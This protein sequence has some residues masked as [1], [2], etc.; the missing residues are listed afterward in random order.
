[1]EIATTCHRY[2]HL[3]GC[4]S[5]SVQTTMLLRPQQSTRV[6][7][8]SRVK[9]QS[10]TLRKEHPDQHWV[11][12]YKRYHLEWLIETK[13]AQ[14][15]SVLF[16]GQDDKARIPVGT[17]IA[18]STNVRS[19]NGAIVPIGTQPT[20]ADH[21]WGYASI[22][23]SVTL[24][25]NIPA[26]MEGSFYGGGNDGDGKIEVVLRDAVFDGSDVFDHAAQLLETIRKE[27]SL[28]Y[29]VVLETDGGPD[30]NL[31]FMRTWLALIALFIKGDLDKLLALR[32]A[33]NG[34]WLNKTERCMSL[35]NFGI[36]NVSLVRAMM[37]LWAERQIE[38]ASS[39]K[40]IRNVAERLRD[41]TNATRVRANNASNRR[42][43]YSSFATTGNARLESQLVCQ[44]RKEGLTCGFFVLTY[45]GRLK[46]SS[47]ACVVIA[48]NIALT[49]LTRPL[50]A[51]DIVQIIDVQTPATIADHNLRDIQSSAFIDL[52]DA[53]TAMLDA[54]KQSIDEDISRSEDWYCHYRLGDNSKID[55]GV[56]IARFKGTLEDKMYSTPQG[57]RVSATFFLNSHLIVAYRETIDH[58]R[59]NYIWHVIDSMA[60]SSAP[61]CSQHY[62]FKSIENLA[63]Y[64]ISCCQRTLAISQDDTKTMIAS[65][66]RCDTVVLEVYMCAETNALLLAN[67]RKHWKR[68]SKRRMQKR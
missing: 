20:A 3:D 53:R 28:P 17:D 49:F 18:L 66:E 33:P 30:H 4:G 48:L 23:P 8:K 43:N 10:R 35:L 40:D 59:R 14:P 6:T 2:L 27:P 21:D 1:M 55:G 41:L 24:R 37:P 44:A 39:M 36:E 47:N 38:N 50:Q 31:M 19:R 57:R 15:G 46:V 9:I 54:M 62:I 63:A 16:Y 58:E 67:Q 25:C 22:V 52:Q 12:A 32:G 65:G 7:Y 29:V 51:E 60:Q 68:P 56:E 45:Q 11:N 13:L 64:L 42:K 61:G 34:S 26:S 5:T